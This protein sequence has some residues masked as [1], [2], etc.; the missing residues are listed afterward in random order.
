MAK[1]K[2]L[3]LTT[4]DNPWDPRDEFFQWYSFDAAHGYKTCEKIDNEA[5]T[6]SDL[7]NAD[8]RYYVEEAIKKIASMYPELY[9]II[10]KED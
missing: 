1:S 5:H 9:K 6:A 3:W 2:S 4:V 10:E 7:A 8:N